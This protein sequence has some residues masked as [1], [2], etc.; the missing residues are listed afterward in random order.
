MDSYPV[1]AVA[2]AFLA[3]ARFFAAF[4]GATFLTAAFLGAAVVVGVAF[5]ASALFVA[6]RFLVAAIIAFLPAAL[7]RRLGFESSIGAFDIARECS[8]GGFFAV[9]EDACNP[10][11]SFTR[12]TAPLAFW[13]KSFMPGALAE[14][15]SVKSDISAS[16]L[17]SR[18][19]A[20]FTFI[21]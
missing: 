16:I 4:T 1:C 15:R 8:K 17:A 14:N 3:G 21:H 20:L 19:R 12:M 9:P 11:A 5:A 10:T 6:Q 18:L 13:S 2:F 7:S